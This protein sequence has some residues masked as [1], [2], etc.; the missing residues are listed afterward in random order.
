MDV[1][2]KGPFKKQPRIEGGQAP[3]LSHARAAEDSVDAIVFEM[4]V[5]EFMVKSGEYCQQRDKL[6]PS[7]A[8]ATQ[9]A[10]AERIFFK[11][12]TS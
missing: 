5:S 11:V 6:S 8:L 7:L 2:H 3:S 12:L 9:Q 4:Y 1:T 10:M